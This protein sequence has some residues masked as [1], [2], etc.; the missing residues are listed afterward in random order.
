ME[1]KVDIRKLQLLNERINQ[2]LDAL[3]QV[4]LSVHGLEHTATPLS[5]GFAPSVSP[6]YGMQQ[7]APIQ[8]S[9]FPGQFPV[10]FGQTGIGHTSP[11]DLEKRML[12]VQA[13][14]PY[15]IAKTFP[16]A[17][18]GRPVSWGW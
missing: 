18:T 16:Y 3:N 7:G 17:F 12:E 4:R 15:R 2:A 13:S 6:V 5:Y 9:Q 8:Q 1:A 14:D 11:E 10:S